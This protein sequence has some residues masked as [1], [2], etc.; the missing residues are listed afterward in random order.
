MAFCAQIVAILITYYGFNIVLPVVTMITVAGALALFNIYSFLRVEDE[1]PVTQYDL[2]LALMV[3]VIVLTLQ[4]LLSGGTSNPL[5]SFYMLPVIIGAITLESRL[6]WVTYGVTIVAYLVLD[7]FGAP[8]VPLAGMHSAHSH[9]GAL[10]DQTDLHMN[11]MMIGYFICAGALVYAVTRI[12]IILAV[13][14]AEYEQLKAHSLEQDHIVRLGLLAGGAAHELGTPLTTLSVILRDWAKLSPPH[15]KAERD[16][17]I[18]TMCAQV[19]YCKTIISDMILASGQ[20][21]GE[22]GKAE[23]ARDF[24]NRVAA[25]W[26]SGNTTTLGLDLPEQNTLIVADRLLEQT[27]VNLLD[28]ALEASKEVGHQAVSLKA[29]FADEHM[30]LEV[31]DSGNGFAPEVLAQPG[32]PFHS[33]RAAAGRGMGLFLVRNTVQSLGGTLDI[34]STPQGSCVRISLPLKSLQVEVYD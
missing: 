1:K 34:A 23:G 16:A 33:T 14:D 25:R 22:G 11:G 19:D 5:V 4:F 26:Q 31:S 20:S 10:I 27:V 18:E 15:K 9:H 17:D 8:S 3:D 24:L 7:A 21:R 28:N 32:Q 6:A 2:F 13:R 29:A 30:V 12:R